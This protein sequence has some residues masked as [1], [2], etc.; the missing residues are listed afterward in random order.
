MAPKSE[1]HRRDG[2]REIS[3]SSSQAKAPVIRSSDTTLFAPSWTGFPSG[4]CR[5][6]QMIESGSL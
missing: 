1:R 3:V 6:E 5:Q 2:V 4:M